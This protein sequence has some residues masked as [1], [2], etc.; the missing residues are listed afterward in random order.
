MQTLFAPRLLWYG[1]PPGRLQRGLEV[2]TGRTDGDRRDVGGGRRERDLRD[3][4]REHGLQPS[5]LG[6]CKGAGLG[7]PGRG[8][9]AVVELV[10]QGLGR[11]VTPGPDR[12]R[13]R[14]TPHTVT[15]REVSP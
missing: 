7:G 11:L 15:T 14:R 2:T 10:L 9:R 12:A 13:L 8:W 1:M 5:V 6:G 3:E 4:V